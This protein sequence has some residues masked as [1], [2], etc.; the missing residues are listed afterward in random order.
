MFSPYPN[1]L[2]LHITHANTFVCIIRI[3]HNFRSH[4]LHSFVHLFLKHKKL[5]NSKEKKSHEFIK[6]MS[7]GGSK[8]RGNCI[9]FAPNKQ[10]NFHVITFRKVS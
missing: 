3:S 4:F 5:A 2:S 8:I 9:T 1:A 6:R 10:Q 7:S